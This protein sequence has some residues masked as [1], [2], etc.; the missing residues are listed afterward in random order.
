MQEE[1]LACVS[2]PEVRAIEEETA[3]VIS[4]FCDQFARRSRGRQVPWFLEQN[5]FTAWKFPALNF[6]GLP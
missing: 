1:D 6:R 5:G 4:W 3:A 2:V